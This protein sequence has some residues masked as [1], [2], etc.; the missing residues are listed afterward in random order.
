VSDFLQ[1]S[2]LDRPL[3][4]Q[5]FLA[6][7]KWARWDTGITMPFC[8]S[9]IELSAEAILSICRVDSSVAAQSPLGR[10]THKAGVLDPKSFRADRN[11]SVVDNLVIYLLCI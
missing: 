7:G 5:V 9:N 6:M 3:K 4:R 8:F 1:S 2:S 11:G 10:K